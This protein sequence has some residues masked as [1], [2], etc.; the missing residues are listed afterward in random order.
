MAKRTHPLD[1]ENVGGD[2]YSLMSKGHHDPDEF[3]RQ[4]RADGYDWPLGAPKHIWLR[5]V[6]PPEGYV[7]WYVEAAEG[8]RGAFPATQCWEAYGDE[9]YRAP[10][11]EPG[12]QKGGAAPL[13]RC[14]AGRD[15]ECGHA[16]CP[17]LRDGEPAKSSRHCPL[18]NNHTED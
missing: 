1:I 16:Q 12:E 6:P 14:A 5:C 4:A 9:I 11:Q 18:D 13:T 7:S 17:Q 15:G 2:T 8:A 10:A 3:M